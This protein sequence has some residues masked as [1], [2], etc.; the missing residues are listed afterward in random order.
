MNV[1]I[2]RTVKKFA[3]SSK[4]EYGYANNYHNGKD[5]VNHANYDEK[6]NNYSRMIY[7]FD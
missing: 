3:R 7:Q 4:L 2:V 1:I 5:K 6:K